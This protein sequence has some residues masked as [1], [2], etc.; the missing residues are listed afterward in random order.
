M[1]YSH[2]PVMTAEVIHYLGLQSGAVVVDGTLG[3]GGHLSEILSRILPG[4][5]VVGIDLDSAALKAATEKIKNK[6][7]VILVQDN[8]K[9][10][11]K[12][13]DEHKL[14]R[15]NGFLLDLGLSSG[16][17]QD[18]E[19]GFS[20][21]AAGSLDMRFNDNNG[22][23]AAEILNTYDQKH[24]IKIFSEY[25]E[26]KLAV[27]IAKKIVDARKNKP[28]KNPQDLVEIIAG[29]YHRY[30]R[31]QSKMNPATKVFQALRIEVNGELENLKTFLPAAVKLSVPGARLVIISYHSLEDKLVKDF[32]RTE[33]RDCICPPS[34]P[35]CQCGHHKTLKIITK[36]PI[37][38]NDAEV[39]LNPRA[40]S[41][42]LRVAEKI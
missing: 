13:A 27:P 12:I 20:F 19:R 30:F 42:K 38:P 15:I 36:K 31:Q 17:L 35:L 24:L 39:A 41:A 26:E 21:L 5:K 1:T 11:K 2:Q 3:G 25:G 14:D 29:A 18:S 33:S 37:V 40:R 32:F 6:K 22:I 16:Q 4:G 7:N 9:N 34:M 23:T 8:F 10:I 28:F